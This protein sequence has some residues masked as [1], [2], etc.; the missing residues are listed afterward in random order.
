MANDNIIVLNDD[1]G[2]EVEF[3]FLDLIPCREKICSF[4]SRI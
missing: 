2:N 1:D 4:T 3:K